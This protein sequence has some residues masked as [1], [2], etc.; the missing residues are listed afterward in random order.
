MKYAMQHNILDVAYEK[1]RLL[2]KSGLKK[3]AMVKL[4]KLFN[5]DSIYYSGHSGDNAKTPEHEKSTE[6]TWL[7]SNAG[8]DYLAAHVTPRTWRRHSALISMIKEQQSR[9]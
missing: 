4:A 3:K 5:R 6:S 8:K 1:P 9:D 2:L 7:R